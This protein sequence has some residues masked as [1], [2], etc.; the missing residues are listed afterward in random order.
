IEKRIEEVPTKEILRK[1]GLKRGEATVV[2]GGP[3]C[4]SFSTAGNRGSVSDPRGGMFR[5]FLRVVREARPRFFVM[6]NVRGVLSAAVKHR[7]LNKRGPGF[8]PLSEEEE[9]GSAL[10]LILDELRSLGYYVV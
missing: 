2:T 1:A 10:K 3:S 8:P 7:P 4:Q 5:E 6:E 9:L